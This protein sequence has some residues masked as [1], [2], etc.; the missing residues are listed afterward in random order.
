[1]IGK[2]EKLKICIRL[3]GKMDNMDRTWRWF[4]NPFFRMCNSKVKDLFGFWNDVNETYPDSMG[5]YQ[6]AAE[7][8]GYDWYRHKDR[9]DEFLMYV[10]GKFRIVM[11]ITCKFVYYLVIA[12]LAYI[13]TRDGEYDAEE[14]KLS[15]IQADMEPPTF[16]KFVQ[17]MIVFGIFLL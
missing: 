7:I 15:T 5:E 8:R 11:R 3:A 10:N 1:M 6:L 17:A 16:Y 2:L 4:I 13:M 9:K 14:N 12:I